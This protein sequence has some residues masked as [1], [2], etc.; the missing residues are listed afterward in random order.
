MNWNNLQVIETNSL[1]YKLLFSSF[2]KSFSLLEQN[3]EL[4]DYFAYYFLCHE[5]IYDFEIKRFIQHYFGEKNLKY[6]RN[7]NKKK[8]KYYLNI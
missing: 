3:R 8:Y 7:T 4:L 1:K 5:I 6:N 2:N